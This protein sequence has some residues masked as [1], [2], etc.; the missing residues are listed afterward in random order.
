MP[1]GSAHGQRSCC[2]AAYRSMWYTLT[3]LRGPL[4]PKIL[5][6]AIVPAVGVMTLLPATV[7]TLSELCGICSTNNAPEAGSRGKGNGK[8]SLGRKDS[9]LPFLGRKPRNVNSVQQTEALRLLHS[10]TKYAEGRCLWHCRL[11]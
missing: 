9:S 8:R 11:V 6:A 3:C 4:P 5:N 7:L 10:E 2:T 1:N